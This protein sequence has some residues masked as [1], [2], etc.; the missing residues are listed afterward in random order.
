MTLDK[1]WMDELFPHHTLRN[2]SNQVDFLSTFRIELLKKNKFQLK[3]FLLFFSLTMEN[4]GY[5]EGSTKPRR[6]SRTTSIIKNEQEQP[7][8]NSNNTR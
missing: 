2:R 4:L 6:I 8:E 5:K 1:I 3:L 7:L